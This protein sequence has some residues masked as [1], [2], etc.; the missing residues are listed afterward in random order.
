[1]Y[2][3]GDRGST[4]ILELPLYIESHLGDDLVRDS[5]FMLEA[6]TDVIN[7]NSISGRLSSERRL[8]ICVPTLK[9]SA[10][11]VDDSKMNRKYM[12]RLL[13]NRMDVIVEAEDGIAA[14]KEVKLSIQRKEAFSVILMDYVMPRM[15]GPTA[16][17]EIRRLGFQGKII[18]ITA[19]VMP[20]AIEHFLAHGADKVL[21]KPVDVNQLRS[22]LPDGMYITSYIYFFIIYVC[23]ILIYKNYI[24]LFFR[25][26]MM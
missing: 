9:R 6:G 24:L 26:K 2:S 25:L 8:S 15:D 5:V 12:F 23:L 1:M 19:N 21:S 10:L 14:I 18:G 22:Y 7:Q 17:R 4:F 20:I 11:L 13:F 16:T 3:D